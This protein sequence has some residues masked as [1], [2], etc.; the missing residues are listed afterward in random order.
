MHYLSHRYNLNMHTHTQ[1]SFPKFVIKDQ[2]DTRDLEG[3]GHEE[4]SNEWC[5]PQHANEFINQFYDV[6]ITIKNWPTK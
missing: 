4:D 3:G 1:L 6:I 2:K 5:D